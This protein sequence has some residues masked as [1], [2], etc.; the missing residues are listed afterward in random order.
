M[1][2]ARLEP[3][4][5][6]YSAILSIDLPFE[7]TSERKAYRESYISLE[8]AVR[9][10]QKLEDDIKSS[11]RQSLRSMSEAREGLKIQNMAVAVAEKRVDSTTLFFEAGRAQIRDLLEA[12]ESL[13]T[14]RNSLT[15]ALIDYRVAE[16]EFQRNTGLLEIDRDGL[17]VEY[18]PEDKNNAE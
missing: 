5:G 12:Q 14:A 15:S 11:V 7:R 16:L 2:D 9:N 8:S 18:T 1:D 10:F 4:K 3:N 17:L 13:L 6:F